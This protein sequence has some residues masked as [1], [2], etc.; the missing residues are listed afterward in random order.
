VPFDAPDKEAAIVANNERRKQQSAAI[1][2]I[3]K[4][5]TRPN[6]SF[7]LTGDMNDVPE[8]EF[9]KSFTEDT[10]LNLTDAMANPTEVG[11]MNNTK[12]PPDK[13][14]WTHRFSPE[15]GHYDYYFIRPHLDK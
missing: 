9:L 4:S 10:E 15:A 5:V 3:I 7:I 12:Y 14:I 1:A 8:S 2:R 11:Q 6:S 13:H